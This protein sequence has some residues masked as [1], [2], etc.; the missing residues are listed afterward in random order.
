MNQSRK[1]AS[2]SPKP[3]KVMFCGNSL[4][5]MVQFRLE[6]M[7]SFSK[8][9]WNVVIISPKNS[10]LPHATKILSKIG[11][12]HQP[13]FNRNSVNPF[14]DIRYFFKL[15]N[16]YRRE[17]PDI[18]FHYTIKPNIYGTLAAKLLG[19][20]SVAMVTGLGYSFEG[21]S[22]LKRIARMLYRVGLRR[23]DRVLV[24]NQ[25]NAK[26][27][28]DGR[29]VPAER[30]TLLPGGEGLDLERYPF[31]QNRYDRLRFLM[32]SRLLYN[33]GY[34][35][36]VEAAKIV[37]Q[38]YP[39]TEFELVGSYDNTSPMHVPEKIVKSDCKSG[40]ITYLGVTDDIPSVVSRDGVVVVLPSKYHEGMNLSLM[41]ACSMGRPVITTD[42]AGCKETVID[43]V[44]GFLCDKGDPES[45]A[46]AIIRF[47]ELP[48]QT[49]VDMSRASRRLAEDR[50]N[51][52]KCI[53]IYKK[54]TSGLTSGSDLQS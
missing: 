54:I 28:I 37:R 1:S 34:C 20:P 16:I 44:N 53:D 42:N 36:F 7:R 30:M 13:D 23:S 39:G 22:L 35:E 52:S 10:C 26:T 43:G 14:H 51:V 2:D 6:V 15:L 18:I 50:F 47:I 21:N 24:L 46:D 38:K 27:L 32:V 49:K 8:R 45:L 41:E 4:S 11:K 17:R 48:E 9:G 25:D 5:G 29:Y 31:R 19:I 33:K 12:I 40:A 3:Q